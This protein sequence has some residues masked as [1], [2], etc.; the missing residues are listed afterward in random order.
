MRNDIYIDLAVCDEII[1]MNLTSIG[2]FLKVQDWCFAIGVTYFR[3]GAKKRCPVGYKLGYDFFRNNLTFA[4]MH[5]VNSKIIT[6]GE[7]KIRVMKNSKLVKWREYQ[8]KQLQKEDIALRSTIDS[9][10]SAR[11]SNEDVQAKNI[12]TKWLI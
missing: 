12:P 5:Y 3:N 6:E 7:W 8:N 9:R 1:Y 10:T 11:K 4:S 2:H